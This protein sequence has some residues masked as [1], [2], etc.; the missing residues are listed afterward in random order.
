MPRP[1]DPPSRET[2]V[3]SF[4]PDIIAGAG[5]ILK[6]PESYS[7][8]ARRID[9]ECIL[10]LSEGAPVSTICRSAFRAGP[11]FG[12]CAGLRQN[13]WESLFKCRTTQR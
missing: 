7:L 5:R 1:P 8:T 6:A 13:V 12:P 4:G 11:F 2:G 10:L 3:P 9:M